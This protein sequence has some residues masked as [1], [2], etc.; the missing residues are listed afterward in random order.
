[1]IENTP[2]ELAKFFAPSTCS[3]HRGLHQGNGRGGI[4]DSQPG[5]N[6]LEMLVGESV[7]SAEHFALSRF[8]LPP[9]MMIA[10][11]PRGICRSRRATVHPPHRNVEQNRRRVQREGASEGVAPSAVGAGFRLGQ[12]PGLLLRPSR[13]E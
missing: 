3:P 7:D 10:G 9:S 6:L 4:F 8:D 11:H 2:V 1:M 5:I 13:R 12:Q